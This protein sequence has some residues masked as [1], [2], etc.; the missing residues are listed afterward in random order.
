MVSKV[1]VSLA[2]MTF[3]LAV[4]GFVVLAVWDVPVAQKEVEKAID[5]AKFLE[6]KT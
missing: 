6:K 2:F 5:T 1:L 4:G 3:V